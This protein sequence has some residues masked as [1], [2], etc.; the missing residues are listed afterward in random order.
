MSVLETAMKRRENLEYRAT[1]IR[2]GSEI[3]DT[4]ND[5]AED[6]WFPMICVPNRRSQ[7]ELA[8]YDGA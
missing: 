8:A 3:D 6:G 7:H 4:F 1:V 5:L 2:S